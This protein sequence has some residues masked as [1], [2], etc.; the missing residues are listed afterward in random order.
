MYISGQYGDTAGSIAVSQLQGCRFNSMC[1]FIRSRHVHVGLL[2]V[3]WFP[4]PLKNIQI[5]YA[6]LPVAVSVCA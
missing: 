1:R 5:G 6:K 3:P 4:P 2:R